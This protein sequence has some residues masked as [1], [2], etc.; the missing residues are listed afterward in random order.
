MSI[1]CVVNQKIIIV[2]LILGDLGRLIQ[3]QGRQL[4]RTS[5][6]FMNQNKDVVSNVLAS[7]RYNEGGSLAWWHDTKL[8]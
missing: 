7:P 3:A 8:E 5:T 6:C 1:N 4:V 2:L